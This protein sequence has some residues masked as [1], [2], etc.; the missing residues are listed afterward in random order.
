M[1]AALEFVR[2]GAGGLIALFGVIFVAGG[3]LGVLRFPDFYTRLHAA[4]VSDG[5]GAVLVCLG[6]ALLAHDGAVAARLVLLALLIG[7]I[8]PLISQLSANAAHVGGLA[9]LSGQY[10]APRPGP[11]REEGDA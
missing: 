10:T 8:G 11:T 3:T 6:L 2:M 4:R 7:A 9:P 1:A 5:V